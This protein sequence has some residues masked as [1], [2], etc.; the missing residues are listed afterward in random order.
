MHYA[1]RT[2]CRAQKVKLRVMF[3]LLPFFRVTAQAG[4]HLFNFYCFDLCLS[5]GALCGI[6]L[7]HLTGIITNTPP[8]TSHHHYNC[9]AYKSTCKLTKLSVSTK[10]MQYVNV[11]V[12][13]R[14]YF[15]SGRFSSKSK[16]I[17]C[18]RAVIILYGEYAS[19]KNIGIFTRSFTGDFFL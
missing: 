17:I 18:I 13:S 1:Y 5:M 10:G 16:I 11:C 2:M 6:T 4:S 15:I 8:P 12:P 7:W 14:M 3:T 9:R 19:L